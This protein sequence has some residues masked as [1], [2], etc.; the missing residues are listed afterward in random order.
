MI[1][2]TLFFF[3]NRTFLL[4]D[5]IGINKALG[6]SLTNSY[7]EIISKQEDKRILKRHLFMVL[8]CSKTLI[9]PLLRVQLSW[10]IAIVNSH[11][12]YEHFV[13]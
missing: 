5:E 12:P 2:W 6:E 13:T 1:I 3:L 8:R 9:R 11:T 4:L 7:L 10:R